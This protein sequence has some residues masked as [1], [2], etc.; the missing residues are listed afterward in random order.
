MVADGKT[1]PLATGGGPS[2]AST[3]LLSVVKRNRTSHRLTGTHASM[4]SRHGRARGPA[5]G[6]R[7][8]LAVIGHRTGLAI[9]PSVTTPPIHLNQTPEAIRRSRRHFRISSGRLVPRPVTPPGHPPGHTV[10]RA[11]RARNL[12]ARSADHSPNRNNYGPPPGPGRPAGPRHGAAY[13]GG[14]SPSASMPSPAT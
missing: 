6:P 1:V 12:F 14:I 5:A 9:R 13:H 10:R 2:P 3:A 8:D 11:R 4:L 7:H